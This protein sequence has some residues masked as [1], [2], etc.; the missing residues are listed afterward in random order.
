MQVYHSMHGSANVQCSVMDDSAFLW[1][2]AILDPRHTLTPGPIDMK[3]CTIDYVG[4]IT[5]YE[6]NDNNRFSGNSH[7]ENN[8]SINADFLQVV[9]F[10]DHEISAENFRNHICPPKKMKKILTIAQT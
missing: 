6:K 1:E 10:R 5:L 3:F 7:L 2:H 9:P 4:E 8:A